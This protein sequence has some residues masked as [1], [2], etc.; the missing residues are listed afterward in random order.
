MFC[1]PGV[2][3]S[4]SSSCSQPVFKFLLTLQART[5]FAQRERETRRKRTRRKWLKVME[6]KSKVDRQILLWRKGEK[7]CEQ[8]TVQEVQEKVEKNYNK[9]SNKREKAGEK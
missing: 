3:F 1:L 2:Y 6:G 9:T 4:A 5:V 7:V 8:G